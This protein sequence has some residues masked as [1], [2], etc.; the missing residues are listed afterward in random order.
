MQ[1]CEKPK[2]EAYPELPDFLI[3]KDVQ[4]VNFR[5]DPQQKRQARRG[6][7]YNHPFTVGAKHVEHA[8]KYC[9]GRLGYKTI[10]AIPCAECGLP[11]TA[12]L[13]DRV[14]FLQLTRNATTA[15]LQQWSEKVDL[16]AYFKRYQ[17]DGLTFVETPEKWRFE[18]NS[19][20]SA[21]E[22]TQ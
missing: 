20:D 5:L 9:H 14:M 10:S 18:P 12:H 13:N 4:E 3:I 7:D 15:E 11:E 6:K 19:G 17:I 8:S 1:R 2:P 22:P 21:D 16:E